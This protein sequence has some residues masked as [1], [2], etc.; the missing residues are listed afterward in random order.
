[1][2][3]QLAETAPAVT[4][5][6]ILDRFV[7]DSLHTRAPQTQRDYLW[8]IA[9]LRREFGH[10]IASELR[11][12]DF[13]PFLEVRKG[14]ANRVRSLAVLSAAFSDAVKRWYILDSNVLRDVARPKS[15][16]R[17]RLVLDE[18]FARCRALAP[19]RVQ[20]AMDLAL[21]TGQ[22]QGD[23]LAF[24]WSDIREDA[25]HVQQ[26]KTGKRLAI[27]IT[28]DLERVL[29]QCWML[30]GSGCDG[31]MYVLPTRFGKR[32]T[33]PGYKSL[34]QRTM[35]KYCRLGGERFHFHDLC[36]LA[37]TKCET[38][39]VAQRLLGHTSISMTLRVYRR[40]VERVKPLQLGA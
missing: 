4:V 17:D 15:R 18:E 30:K 27:E 24:K 2:N 11:P 9:R 25:L 29:D 35:G 36:A 16:P 8:H 39:E 13:G 22:R 33:S 21:L 5:A 34:W 40:G 19:R 6:E 26:S 3:A 7:R 37:A 31:G 20:L 38:P 10:R 32:Y 14:R 28:P 1:M 23:I 12:R